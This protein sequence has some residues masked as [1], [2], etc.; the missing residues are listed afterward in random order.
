MI[1]RKKGSI[2]DAVAWTQIMLHGRS[3][4]VRRG[5]SE[6]GIRAR[7]MLMSVFA[8]LLF[9]LLGVQLLSVQVFSSSDYRELANGNRVRETIL[10]APRGKITDRHGR[11]LADNT[12]SFQLSVTP[13]LLEE[14]EGARQADIATVSSIADID[15][16]SEDLKFDQSELESV[17]P[18]IV[19]Q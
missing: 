1:R 8:I 13:F 19:A 4:E 3:V 17:L 12:L 10:Y 18:R 6:G 15:E 9:L 5:V 7:L 2:D 16:Q 14:N 11:I